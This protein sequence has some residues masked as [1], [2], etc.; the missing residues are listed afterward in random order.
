VGT[1]PGGEFLAAL[2]AAQGV[3]AQASSCTVLTVPGLQCRSYKRTCC[4]QTLRTFVVWFGKSESARSLSM[5]GRA[6]ADCF[7]VLFACPPRPAGCAGR[8]RPE[9]HAEAAQLLHSVPHSPGQPL[10]GGLPARPC[11]DEGG[12]GS[13][14]HQCRSRGWH[15]AHRRVGGCLTQA[16]MS[17]SQLCHALLPCS[18][19]MC[20]AGRYAAAAQ[21]DGFKPQGGW[22]QRA[23]HRLTDFD[24]RW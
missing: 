20:V 8:P 14:V 13:A 15:P 17:T 10:P 9:C 7:I 24:G 16:L 23:P 12:L 19:T 6:E 5:A 11:S 2:E 21:H 18:C 3:G 1:M 4:L 22:R